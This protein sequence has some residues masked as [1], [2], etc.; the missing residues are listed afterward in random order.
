VV[1]P[2]PEREQQGRNGRK[3]VKL[4][5]VVIQLADNFVEC[6][7]ISSMFGV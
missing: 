1:L 2:V 4:K 5:S 3:R 6:R 7:C